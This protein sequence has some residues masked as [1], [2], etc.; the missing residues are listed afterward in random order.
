[1]TDWDER[2]RD[3]EPASRNPYPVLIQSS[4]P[5]AALDLACGAER[6]RLG[7]VWQLAGDG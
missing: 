6:H 2:Y 7:Y 3:R 5:A 4:A 1:M